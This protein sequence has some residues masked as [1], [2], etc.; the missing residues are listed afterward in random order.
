MEKVL[1]LPEFSSSGIR[2][3]VYAFIVFNATIVILL[4]LIVLILIL[5]FK[6]QRVTNFQEKEVKNL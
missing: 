2:I 1:Y 5:I 4:V 6:R 3:Y